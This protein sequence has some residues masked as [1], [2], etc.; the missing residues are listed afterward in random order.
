[1]PRSI[2]TALW[3]YSAEYDRYTYLGAGTSRAADGWTFSFENIPERDAVTAKKFTSYLMGFPQLE[4]YYAGDDMAEKW[5]HYVKV[6]FERP[7]SGEGSY[8]LDVSLEPNGAYD[9]RN[10]TDYTVRIFW[11]D[12][13]NAEQV[14]NVRVGH[15]SDR[16]DGEFE[17]GIQLCHSRRRCQSERNDG[18]RI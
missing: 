14:E 5:Q 12:N 17:E 4:A 7:A 18:T 3:G 15:T 6:S 10:R 9:G 11:A 13:E 1:M 8:L 16:D 2:E